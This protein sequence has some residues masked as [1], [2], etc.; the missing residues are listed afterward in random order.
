[1]QPNNQITDQ[2]SNLD[3]D[4]AQ[5][6]DRKEQS[7]NLPTDQLNNLSTDQQTDRSQSPLADR[8]PSGV[9]AKA[10]VLVRVQG[11]SKKFCKDLKTS[12]KY[13]VMDLS[14]QIFSKTQNKELRPKEFWAVR[15]VS[16]EL[17]R[18]ECLGLIGH[19]GA[20]KSTLLK[21]LN[22]LI[23]PDEGRIEMHGRVA[24]LI[25]LGAGF[26]PILTGRENIYNNGTVLGLKRKE[27]D[28]VLEDI[29]DFSEL[30]EFIDT[31]VQNYSSGMKV[32]LGFSVATCIKPDILI[33]DEVLAVGDAGF[34]IKSFNK[35]A[36]II[37]ECTV[38]FVSHSMPTMMRICS[39]MV[40]LSHGQVKYLGDNVNHA[41][42]L[43]YQAFEGE[44]SKI[45]FNEGAEILD[46]ICNKKKNSLETF[47]E[48]NY[49]DDLV[50]EFNL[51]F[52]KSIKLFYIAIVI[53]DKDLKII[54]QHF[55]NKFHPNFEVKDTNFLKF[56]FPNVELIDGDYTITY[57]VYEPIGNGY[58]I[59]ATYRNYTKI[60]IKGLNVP[61]YSSIFL[62]GEITFNNQQL[63][64]N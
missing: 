20:G 19:N 7:P 36:S 43:Y 51:R 34:K 48:L 35:I 2:L 41:I 42:E 13:G 55:S 28:E 49:F 23:N 31:P 15:D 11:V 25:E 64:N 37:K 9:E 1:M 14:A 3:F 59:L 40:F 12:L 32:R 60:R 10:E 29:I 46:I 63:V 57:F 24:A 21:M 33:L 16:F 62:K 30:R 26:N 18:G 4:S 8:W 27:I 17:R 5:S 22:G 6:A 38:I 44:Q 58:N 45:E 56:T 50:L 39:K 61:V 52:K 53:I 54:A 47:V